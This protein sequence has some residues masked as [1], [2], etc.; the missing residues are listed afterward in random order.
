M[1]Q[2]NQPVTIFELPI[3]KSTIQTLLKHHSPFMLWVTSNPSIAH[4]IKQVKP[5]YNVQWIT[6][7]NIN[8][9]D[10]VVAAIEQQQV[11]VIVLGIE[12]LLNQSK[13]TKILNLITSVSH[14]VI[15]HIHHYSPTSFDYRP[16]Y[17]Y[18][19]ILF[20]TLRQAHWSLVSNS[21]SEFDYEIIKSK[22]N[23]HYVEKN[24]QHLDHVMKHQVFDL[25]QL[26]QLLNETIMHKSSI[27]VTHDYVEAEIIAFL[28]NHLTPCGVVHRKVDESK[29]VLTLNQWQTEEISTLVITS[30][31]ALPYP[32]PSVDQ[33]IWLD[34]PLSLQQLEFFKELFAAQKQ[35]IMTYHSPSF[36]RSSMHQFPFDHQLDEIMMTLKTNN[37][38]LTMR[39]IERFINID[40]YRCEKAMKGL[41]VFGQV[42]KRNMHY[43]PIADKP[44]IKEEVENTQSKKITCFQDFI[45]K[46]N[47][48][49]TYQPDVSD[50]IYNIVNHSTMP[51]RPKILFPITFYPKSL[52]LKH[53]QTEQGH[54]FIRSID[55][56]YLRALDI[57][58]IMTSNENGTDTQAIVPLY[59][60]EDDMS[61]LIIH[62]SK[63]NPAPVCHAFEKF[64]ASLLH[65]M[66]NP[67]HK[68]T[69]IMKQ[70]TLQHTDYISDCVFV[71][72]NHGD[73]FWQ[74]GVVGYELL[75][76]NMCKKVVVIFNQP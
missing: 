32:Y 21:L 66:K 51:V 30:D 46:I 57:H 1:I 24:D 58:H 20:N 44:L 28:L 38:G 64:D 69:M 60:H 67:F 5:N 39:E 17:E 50:T 48:N 43:F 35:M 13:L 55:D 74:M 59:N 8:E 10:D 12:Q 11:D 16:E 22:I 4:M 15:D 26:I 37:H 40:S 2:A 14:V 71:I 47:Q 36:S 70:I 56:P 73:H 75:S 7:A 18:L 49:E 65:T 31:T 34:Y 76:R 41:L 25:S 72:A 68:M 53:H 61:E 3:S 9:F 33:T 54:L 63:I 6:G 45:S 42:I 23:I 29:K 19:N 27:I 62:L 52:I